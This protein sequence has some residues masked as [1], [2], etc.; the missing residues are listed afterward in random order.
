MA[1]TAEQ[2][3]YCYY[4]IGYVESRNDYSA[5]NQVDA[6]TLGI[7]QWYG[8]NAWRLLD[9][10]RTDAPDS[11]AMLSD[12]LRSLCEGGEQTWNYWTNIYLVDDDAQS[13]ANAATLDS[14]HAVQDQLFMNDLFG[15]GGNYD[16]MRGWGLGDDPKVA[17]FYLAMYHQRPAS[18]STCMATIGGSPT[19]EKLRDWCL[20]NQILGS[21]KNRYNDV[22][23]LL[24]QWDGT[25]EPP[26]FGQS[27]T[28]L[29]T[30]PSDQIQAGTLQSEV[31]YVQAVGDD[32]V[33]FGNMA[34]TG[35]LL[36]HSTGRGIW[37]P[38]TG[39]V[40][41]NPGGGGEDPNPDVPPAG[42][43]PGEF[44]AMRQLW[45]ENASRWGYSNGPG[46]LQ[47]DVYGY[48]DCSACIYWAANKATGG[49]YDWIG[50][51]TDYMVQNCPIV[52]ELDRATTGL[53]VDRSLLR[54]GDLLVVDYGA[55][56]YNTPGP[57]HVDWYWGNGVVWGAGSAPLPKKISDNVDTLYENYNPTVQH[58]WVC[59]FL[60]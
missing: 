51:M 24:T 5:T 40:P 54:P 14:N 55:G 23:R 8:Q 32:L 37:V 18:A 59:R 20:S 12:R 30:D 34:S 4:V 19:L 13:W 38:V 21:Y 2:M 36:C 41:P 29:P 35:R 47:P 16:V 52:L 53:H 31:S 1:L 6:I 39:T 48:S 3:Q 50:T 60:D 26:D 44:S 46:R 15:E 10:V 56:S 28:V 58:L 9:A 25:S 45:E 57:D 22:Y 7:T 33:I 49:K 11:Y 43:D 42:D 27:E 17:I